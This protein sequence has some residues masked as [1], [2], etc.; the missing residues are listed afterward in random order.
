MPAITLRAPALLQVQA[1][2]QVLAQTPT[3]LVRLPAAEDQ[4]VNAFVAAVGA[5]TAPV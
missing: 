5:L 3:Q 1:P 2:M 4:S